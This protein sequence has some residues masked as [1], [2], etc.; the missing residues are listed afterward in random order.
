ME[1]LDYD[2]NV[3]SENLNHSID[4]IKVETRTLATMLAILS[5]YAKHEKHEKHESLIIETIERLATATRVGGTVVFLA[6]SRIPAIV[7]FYSAGI[8][9]VMRN[10]YKFL[11]RLFTKIRVKPIHYYQE[12]FLEFSLPRE[13]NDTFRY[14]NSA[15]NSRHPFE[16]K[17]MHLYICEIYNESKLIFNELKV[18]EYCDIFEL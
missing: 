17:F 18:M 1:S 10:N 11:N 6:M 16:Q 15:F 3:T 2:A 7:G 5:Y 14:I 13:L 4:R 12:R 8:S 9:S